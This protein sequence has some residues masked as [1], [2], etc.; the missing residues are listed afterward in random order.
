MQGLGILADDAYKVPVSTWGGAGGP[1][2]RGSIVAAPAAQPATSVPAAQP[3]M[4]SF[5]LGALL[6][7]YGLTGAGQQADAGKNDTAPGDLDA[8]SYQAP[9]GISLPG[10]RGRAAAGM[11]GVGLG[12]LT[13]NPLLGVAG[14]RTGTGIYD[15]FNGNDRD[16][17]DAHGGLS[18]AD[19]T[20]GQGGG[21]GGMGSD[22]GVGG[23]AVSRQPGRSLQLHAP[24]CLSAG[25]LLVSSLVLPNDASRRQQQI[26]SHQ[27][28]LEIKRLDE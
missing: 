3:A 20:G 19:H 5:D 6:R 4:A 7:Q 16:G 9:A 10:D 22:Y 2:P 12:L 26:A 24:I 17:S 15:Y 8:Q 18:E 21:Y 28:P 27:Y 25:K 13:G 1:A 14:Y 23:M 11:G